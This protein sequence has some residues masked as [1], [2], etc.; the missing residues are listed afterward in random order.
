MFWQKNMLFKKYTAN[1]DEKSNIYTDIGNKIEYLLEVEDLLRRNESFCSDIAKELRMGDLDFELSEDTYNLIKNEKIFTSGMAEVWFVAYPGGEKEDI[2][3]A[4]G[5]YNHMETGDVTVIIEK[6]EKGKRFIY[7]PDSEEWIITGIYTEMQLEILARDT[8]DPEMLA[9]A[10]V[11]EE[12]TDIVISVTDEEMMHYFDANKEI[13]GL[14]DG[15]VDTKMSRIGILDENGEEVSSISEAES[16]EKEKNR[17]LNGQG[18]RL[19]VLPENGKFGTAIVYEDGKYAFYSLLN[20]QAI[21]LA[22]GGEVCVDLEQDLCN[23]TKVFETEN[24][25][26]AYV[27]LEFLWNESER[28]CL[29]LGCK[30][31]FV[32]PLSSSALL[33]T[34]DFKNSFVE[35][36]AFAVENL[37]KCA[38]LTEEEVNRYFCFR[39]W[40]TEIRE[41]L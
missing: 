37:R 24:E 25:T 19:A 12:L 1:A 38:A 20:S 39:N 18:Y 15:A 5:F 22:S 23:M 33:L 16:A 41:E 10:N 9:K 2:V 32:T 28:Y 31:I 36:G 27:F 17:I 4:V 21:Q 26:D 29:T 40:V 3:L 7:D 35:L 6:R 14:Y 30:E 34:R 8:D 13:I 11:L